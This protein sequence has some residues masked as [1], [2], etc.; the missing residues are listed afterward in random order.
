MTTFTDS[1]HVN[2]G[3]LA[4]ALADRGYL[5]P[6]QANQMCDG[7]VSLH[8]MRQAQEAFNNAAA[9]GDGESAVLAAGLA[10][11]LGIA[12]K[13]QVAAEQAGLTPKGETLN[14]GIVDMLRD[15]VN[16]TRQSATA[17]APGVTSVQDCFGGASNR[18]ATLDA[19]GVVGPGSD[20][21]ADASDADAAGALPSA[22]A[23]DVSGFGGGN[24]VPRDPS[25]SSGYAS[26][27]GAY[28]YQMPYNNNVAPLSML[29][30]FA[31]GSLVGSRAFGRSDWNN[32]WGNDWAVPR[33]PLP[34]PAQFVAP[35]GPQQT[36]VGRQ[37]PVRS[38]TQNRVPTQ[39]SNNPSTHWSSGQRPQSSRPPNN[40]P[41]QHVPVQQQQ[42]TILPDPQ[43]VR[44]RA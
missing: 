2:A 24:V 19:P 28:G 33:R 8:N 25:Y 35:L 6:D 10:A 44:R 34:R 23:A 31:V 7:F 9:N 39:P 29:T 30:A 14:E 1:A 27:Y 20:D 12:L 40:S 3:K 4:S 41:A 5:S 13:T 18:S 32:T 15:V 16:K 17:D 37:Q 22:S 26:P 38:P 43:H 36:Q 21:D 11:H 42:P